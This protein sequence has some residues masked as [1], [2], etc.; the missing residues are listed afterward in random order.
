MIPDTYKQC[1]IYRS[2]GDYWESQEL[3]C[4]Q[5]EIRIIDGKIYVLAFSI[6]FTRFW[7]EFSDPNILGAIGRYC[8]IKRKIKKAKPKGSQ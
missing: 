5:G 1:G 3:F 4:K 6:L 2:H 8:E 7:S